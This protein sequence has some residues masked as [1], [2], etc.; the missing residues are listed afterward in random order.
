MDNNI[1]IAQYLDQRM[2]SPA[3]ENFM[4]IDG[5]IYATGRDGQGLYRLIPE[6]QARFFNEA[7]PINVKFRLKKCLTDEKKREA[8]VKELQRLKDRE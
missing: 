5:V 3:E 2:V 7:V 6:G 4:T 8:V 1:R